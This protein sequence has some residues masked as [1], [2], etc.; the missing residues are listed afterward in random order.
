MDDWC[1]GIARK[2]IRNTQE[3]ALPFVLFI[4]LANY[5][6]LNIMLAIS[7]DQMKEVSHQQKIF[8]GECE[9]FSAYSSQ[10][11]DPK[12]VVIK[13]PM[14]RSL[15][16]ILKLIEFN[17]SF[18][19]SKLTSNEKIKDFITPETNSVDRQNEVEL[20]FLLKELKKSSKEDNLNNEMIIEFRGKTLKIKSKKVL[21]QISSNVEL[22]HYSKNTQMADKFSK[23]L[24]EETKLLLSPKKIN[25]EKNTDDDILENETEKLIK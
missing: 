17:H 16:N 2:L 1:A 9:T 13:H 19:Y 6:L 10:I 3:S 4:F 11:S 15:I 7:C 24:S 22:I 23:A 14:S 25:D 5:I 18:Y 21:F 20:Y 12:Y 8:E